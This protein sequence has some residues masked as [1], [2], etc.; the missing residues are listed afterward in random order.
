VLA[1]EHRRVVREANP[2]GLFDG[3][4]DPQ[5]GLAAWLD[6]EAVGLQ[7]RPGIVEIRVHARLPVLGSIGMIAS[8]IPNRQCSTKSSDRIVASVPL[9]EPGPVRPQGSRT[10][11]SS[12]RIPSTMT[13]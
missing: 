8:W 13:V 9:P 10:D 12:P 11:K 7:R 5:P 2:A 6:G 1:M 3:I 4:A